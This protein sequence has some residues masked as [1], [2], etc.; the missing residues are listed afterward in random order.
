MMNFIKTQ[1]VDIQGQRKV[2]M[3]K[4]SCLYGMLLFIHGQCDL[5]IISPGR[6]F[7]LLGNVG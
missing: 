7:G 4:V 5:H 2:S 1:S 3:L 6:T